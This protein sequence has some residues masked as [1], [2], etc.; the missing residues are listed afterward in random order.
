MN[1]EDGRVSL[2]KEQYN[3]LIALLEKSNMEAKCSANVAK[4]SGFANA[5]DRCYGGNVT[6][7]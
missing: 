3:G 2:T 7:W 4:A 5:G 1:E 6:Q